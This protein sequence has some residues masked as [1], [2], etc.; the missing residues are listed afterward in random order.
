MSLRKIIFFTVLST[1]IALTACG[2]STK[3]AA[4]TGVI[5]HT[6]RM[7]L[8][9]DYVVTIRIEDITNAN[10]PGKKI[11]E[12]VHKSQGEVLPIPF[13]IVYDPGKINPDHSY[14]IQV[15]IADGTGTV[16]YT[17]TSNVPVLT[18]GNPTRDIKVTVVLPDN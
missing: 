10:A 4:L 1:S 14:S 17:N 16:L 6:H 15:D 5:A 12:E 7:A 9:A 13:A 11:A 8:P 3:K 2:G 18:H